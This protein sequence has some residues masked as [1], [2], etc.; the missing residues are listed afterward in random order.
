MPGAAMGQTQVAGD[1]M[2][3]MIVTAVLVAWLVAA[4]TVV[5]FRGKQLST[6]FCLMVFMSSSLGAGAAQYLLWSAMLRTERLSAAH[7]AGVSALQL[8]AESDFIRHTLASPEGEA[9]SDELIASDIDWEG[10]FEMKAN[11]ISATLAA[12]EQ[13]AYIQKNYSAWAG[14]IGFR[15]GQLERIAQRVAATEEGSPRQTSIETYLKFVDYTINIV[16]DLAR[17]LRSRTPDAYY[18]E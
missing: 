18:S 3:G 8:K 10:T 2:N 12:V 4:L 15:R 5:A 13:N 9:R 7:L 17:E 14:D 1:P 16:E 6:R 11:D